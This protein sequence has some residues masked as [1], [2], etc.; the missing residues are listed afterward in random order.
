MAVHIVHFTLA[1]IDPAG[2]ERFRNICLQAV[3]QG[4]ATELIVNFSSLGGA[5]IAGFMLYNEIRSLPIPVTFHNVGNVESMAV[6]VYLAGARRKAVPHA[7][8]LLHSLLWGFGAGTVDHARLRE[9]VSTLDNDL[10]RYAAIFDE[11]TRSAREVVDVRRHLSGVE[12]VLTAQ[13]AV[14]CGIV[15]EVV[16][17]APPSQDAVA[18][19]VPPQ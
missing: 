7:R 2:A 12:R 18:W 9:Y 19:W 17:V 6:L 15:H 16:D 3:Y 4:G 14:G 11:R 10:D 1:H 8:F 5:N 13:E